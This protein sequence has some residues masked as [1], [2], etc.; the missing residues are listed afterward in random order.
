[1]LDAWPH[2][3]WVAY[4][5]ALQYY[6]RYSAEGLEHLDGGEARMIV[7]Y[8]GRPLAFDMCMLTIAVYDRLGYLPHG[9]VHRGVEY[10]RPMRWLARGIGF[11]ITDG[12]DLVAAIRR[13][14]HIITTPGGG[15]E[16]CRRFDDSYRVNWGERLGYVRLAVKHGL[17]IV[18]AASAGADSGYIG[19]NS[20]PAL[21]RALGLPKDYAF[22]VW[23]GIGLTGLYP[24]SPAF[25]VRMH[26]M[27]GPPLDPRDD[28]AVSP[29][30]RPAL[31][32]VH[33]RV[34]AAVQGLLDEAR[35]R[36]RRGEV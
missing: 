11:V 15:D 6:H 7:G 20:G 26:S 5:R 35:A 34:V 25:P 17:K 14:E 18:P 16:G 29:D 9:M 33:R 27:V 36:M 32:R 8:H 3:L 24:L 19:L 13:G 28:G 2:R 12:P 21:G 30:D 23:T 4:W 31:L 10:V 1:M 22:I